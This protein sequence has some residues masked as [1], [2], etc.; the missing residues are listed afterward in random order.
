MSFLRGEIGGG[1]ETETT[2]RAREVV[3]TRGGKPVRLG[4]YEDQTGGGHGQYAQAR[5]I[6]AIADDPVRW[7]SGS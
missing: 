3:G 4:K 2:S 7:A 5:S 1:A 6:T